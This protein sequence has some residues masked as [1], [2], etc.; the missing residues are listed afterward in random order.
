MK[1]AIIIP[2]FGKLPNYFLLFQK[3]IENNKKFDFIFYT[4]QKIK[5]NS[6]N[7]YINN[8]TFKSL[9]KRIQSI[10][11]FP[12]SLEKPYKLCDYRP[13]Y[14]EIFENDLIG[15][16]Y[17]GHCD[18]D[19]IFGDMSKFIKFENMQDY[20]KI[21]EYGH[22][23]LYKNNKKNNANYRNDS[24]LNF[25]NVY[26][27]RGSWCFDEKNGIQKIFDSLDLKTYKRNEILD[28]SPRHYQLRRVESD[29]NIKNYK[30]QV[31]YYKEGKIYRCYD[32]NLT[33]KHEEFLYIHLQK[34]KMNVLCNNFDSYFIT[35]NS[36]IDK[37]LNKNIENEDFQKYNANCFLGE[38]M[39]WIKNQKYQWLRRYNKYY[40]LIRRK[41]WFQY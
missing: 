8:I 28:I 15:Y 26:Q 24:I 25:K 27:N 6:K 18:T 7:I 29:K 33:I 12:I 2:Y 30:K 14:G 34:R 20:D 21:Y 1:I 31:F 22:L 37:D 19:M 5:S 3:S 10:F 16:D 39:Y 23:C 11:D 4:D 41:K 40:D 9:K 17:W 38:I 35:P 32:D 36:F 13:A